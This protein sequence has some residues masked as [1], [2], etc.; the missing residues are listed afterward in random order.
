MNDKPQTTKRSRAT[1]KWYA[2]V[3]PG[4]ASN[5]GKYIWQVRNLRTGKLFGF[6]LTEYGALSYANEMN[7]KGH[8]DE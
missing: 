7:L 3:M 4:I 2:E 8:V 1:D 5:R 6:E